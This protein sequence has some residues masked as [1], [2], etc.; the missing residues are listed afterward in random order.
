MRIYLWKFFKRPDYGK[1]IQVIALILLRKAAR[2]VPR[3]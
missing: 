1:T 3:P 2:T